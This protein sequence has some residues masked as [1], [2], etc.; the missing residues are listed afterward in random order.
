MFSGRFINNDQPKNSYKRRTAHKNIHQSLSAAQ[1]LKC[2]QVKGTEEMMLRAIIVAV[3]LHL[4]KSAFARPGNLQSP[5]PPGKVWM[6]EMWLFF[7]LLMAPRR[8]DYSKFGNTEGN[9]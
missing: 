9:L 4:A 5:P 2:G 1:L 6:I 8:K 3:F 7:R